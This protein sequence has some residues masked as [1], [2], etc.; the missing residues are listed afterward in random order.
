V[1]LLS[2]RTPVCRFASILSND[3][4]LTR[5]TLI[6]RYVFVL[7]VLGAFCFAGCNSLVS[8]QEIGELP[9]L[10]F[11]PAPQLS[12][13][14]VIL[15]VG[16]VPVPENAEAWRA[17][18][19]SELD[20]QHLDPDLRRRLSAN[21]F[22]CG[23][24]GSQLPTGLRAAL[25]EAEERKAAVMDSVDNV[26][27]P[28]SSHRRIQNRAGKRSEVVTC[29]HRDSMVVLLNDEDEVAGRTFSH[30]QP[31]IA[32]RSFPLGDGRARVELTPELQHGQS[33]QRW[34][35]Q[36]GAFQLEEGQHSEV[37]SKLVIDTTIAPGQI[38][39]IAA[40]GPSRSLG[41]NF[42]GLGHSDRMEKMLLVRL[43][44]SQYDDLFVHTD[45]PQIEVGSL[46]LA[47]AKVEAEEIVGTAVEAKPT[48]A[49]PRPSVSE[50]D[51]AKDGR[52]SDGLTIEW[53]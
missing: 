1:I 50:E 3:F 5:F 49:T 19:W 16:F 30:V 40:D 28:V 17:D 15:E 12:S 18:V 6:R 25:D 53:E 2:S 39:V 36:D 46:N 52:S 41:G 31:V 35:G 14:S 27:E 23:L 42:F 7:L 47:E 43:A 10:P 51:D 37:Y 26:A 22:R 29:A 45:E 34:V 44:Q 48:L 4:V 33:R 24:C 11:L 8:V 21:G 32:V 38:L 9:S 13:D 20:E